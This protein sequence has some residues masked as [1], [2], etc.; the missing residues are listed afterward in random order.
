[1]RSF[2]SDLIE[3]SVPVRETLLASLSVTRQID[4]TGFLVHLLLGV[5]AKI[6]L[7]AYKQVELNTEWN[8]Q[9]IRWGSRRGV[10]R[11]PDKRELIDDLLRVH[12]KESPLFSMAEVAVERPDHTS[13]QRCIR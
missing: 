11:N 1:M 10:E 12:G 7:R 4:L 6:N 8:R 5:V 3:A 2:P 9:R 13:V